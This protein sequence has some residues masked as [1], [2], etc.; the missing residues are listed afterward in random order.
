[1]ANINLPVGDAAN[2]QLLWIPDTTY[3]ELAEPGTP[4]AAR[5]PRL[6]PPLPVTVIAEA[7]RPDNPLRDGDFG[8]A[9]RSF[10]GGWDLSLNYLYHYLDTPAL[11]V[12]PLATGQL[13]LAPEY[14]R[15]HMLGGTFGTALGSVTLRGE[16]AYNSDTYQP[17]ASLRNA[18]VGESAE[19][20]SVLGLDWMPGGDTLVSAQWFNSYLPD[21]EPDM[22]R[23]SAEQLLTLLYQQDFV[24]AT[25]QFRALGMHSTNDGDSLLQLKLRYWLRS[26]LELW[27]GADIFEGSRRGLFGQYDSEDRLLFGLQY[28]F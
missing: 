6:L 25:W 4:F 24:N 5:S 19:L 13:L 12:R 1:M 8:F 10:V 22:N 27:V 20:S 26:N 3:H 15:S 14:R 9:L 21:H 11:R 16:L 17:L 2:L 7:E 23:D 28:G 18:A